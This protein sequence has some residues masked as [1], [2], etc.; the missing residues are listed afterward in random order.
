M[1]EK[2]VK[3][4]KTQSLLKETI[5][6]AFGILRDEELRGLCVT[7]VDCS[8][9][10]YSAK[11]YLDPMYLDLEEQSEVL[12]KLKKA[13]SI[14]QNYCLNSESWYRC[15]ILSFYFDHDLEKHNRID[16]LFK[17]IAK[18]TKK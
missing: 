17:E 13:K 18:T 11:V 2:S 10:K 4:L 1:K 5:S 6:E 9:G 7:D 3:I 16:D 8:K 12:K 15:P 14:I